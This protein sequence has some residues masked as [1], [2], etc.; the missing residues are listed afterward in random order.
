MFMSKSDR[1]VHL[2]WPTALVRASV[3]LARLVSSIER[4]EGPQLSLGPTQFM[5]IHGVG[6]YD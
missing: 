3:G 2:S 1:T 5:I 6:H 4:G